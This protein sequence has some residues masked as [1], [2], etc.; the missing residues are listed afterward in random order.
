MRPQAQWTYIHTHIHTYIHTYIH[1]QDAGILVLDEATSAVDVQ[2]EGRVMSEIRP[3][4]ENKTT[5]II[6]HRLST[7]AN[8]DQI[9]VLHQGR[10]SLCVCVCVRVHMYQYVC[11]CMYVYDN[12]RPP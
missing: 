6:A 5:L 1:A 11:V 7:V 9:V 3:L 10:V 4:R 2:T 12:I 8:A